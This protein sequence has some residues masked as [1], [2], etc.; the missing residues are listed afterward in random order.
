MGTLI[1]VNNPIGQVFN[2]IYQNG[3]SI[4]STRGSWQI[5][6]PGVIKYGM[7]WTTTERSKWTVSTNHLLLFVADETQDQGFLIRFNDFSD[8]WG[9]NDGGDGLLSENCGITFKTG[10]I[11][12]ETVKV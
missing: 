12:W 10:L 1:R 5:L 2:V 9:L 6:E 3:G 11:R 8:F 7:G 4:F